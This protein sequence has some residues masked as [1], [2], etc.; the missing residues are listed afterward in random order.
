MEVGSKSAD[1]FCITFLGVCNFPEVD[2]WAVP[3]P[4]KPFCDVSRAAPSGKDPI[5]V[6][7]YSDIHIDPLYTEGASTECGLPTCC[8]LVCP[9]LLVEKPLRSIY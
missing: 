7:H 4:S 8:R 1:Q 9:R 3:F 2:K 5:Q 6:I